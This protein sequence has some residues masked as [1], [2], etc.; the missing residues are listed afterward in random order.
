MDKGRRAT[1]ATVLHRAA[2]SYVFEVGRCDV[3]DP[4]VSTVGTGVRRAAR[5]GCEREIVDLTG[6][7]VKRGGL[8]ARQ[9]IRGC[10]TKG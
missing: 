6:T 1:G 2:V 4:R 9:T 3:G 10:E 7:R 8:E 5:L